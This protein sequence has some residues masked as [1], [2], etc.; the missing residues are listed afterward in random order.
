MHQAGEHLR[1]WSP[2]QSQLKTC[3]E[4]KKSTPEDAVDQC[5]SHA[6]PNIDDVYTAHRWWWIPW[7]EMPETLSDYD[8][9]GSEFQIF[10]SFVT[11]QKQCQ[12]VP[13]R[14]AR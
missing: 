2:N 5:I 6:G 14:N 9:I 7:A 4:V 8:G 10:K 12:H 13:C 1:M 11:V 3:V